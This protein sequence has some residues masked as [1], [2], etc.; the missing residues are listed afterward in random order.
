MDV[1][2]S[3]MPM[4][5][6]ANLLGS[7][8]TWTANLAVPKM[9]TCETPLMLEMAG[10]IRVSAYSFTM[11]G[12]T[13]CE[14]RPIKRMGWSAGFT[15]CTEGGAGMF[16]GRRR[17]TA[18]IADCTSCDAAS[19]LRSR[20]NCMVMPMLPRTLEEVIESRPGTVENWRARGVAT[21]AAMVSGLAPGRAAWTWRVGKSMLGRSLT[22]SW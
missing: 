4:P 7:S 11:R 10:E 9:L 18:E 21:E 2:T 3:S 20:T 6:A 1:S 13:V 5:R 19:I 17:I 12:E 22:E 14:L 16:G 8:C 15:F